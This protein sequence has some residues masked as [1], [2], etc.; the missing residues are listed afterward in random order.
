MKR[1]KTVQ[2]TMA[3]PDTVFGWSKGEV[4]KP[5]TIN[6]RTFKPERDGLFCEKIFGPTKDYEC[7][8]GKYKGKK[9]E[10]TVCERCNVRVEPKSSRRK[11]M[12]HIQLAA[13]V[14]HLW[15]LKS[16]PSILSNLLN[17]TSKNLENIIYFGSR[18]II[19][20]IFVIVDRKDTAFDNGDTLYET[21]HDIYSLFWDFEAE[22]AVTVK[23]PTGPVKSEIQG[24]VSI[25]EEETHTGKTLYWVTVTDKVS[26]PYAV[27]KNRTINFKGGQEIQAGQ[28]LVS[29]QTIPAI[30]SPIDGT[31]ELDEGLGTLTIDPIITSGDQPVNFQIPFNA[32]VTVK[33]ND[34]VKKGDRLTLEVTYPAILAEKS[35][36]VVFDKGLSVKPLPDGRHEA[37]SNGKVL[38]ENIIEQKRYPI[39]EGSILYVNEGEMVEKD[40]HI[41]DR[42]VYEEEILSLTEYRILEEHYPGMFNAEG[43][44]ENDRPIMV[45]TEIDP[46]VSTEIEKEAGDILT[47]NEYEAYRTVY[48]GKIEARTGAEAVKILLTKL[49]LE[50][51]RVE[52]ENELRELPKSSAR[53]IKLRKR[54][55]IIKDLLLSGNDPTWMVLNVLPVIPPELR[56][57]IQIEGGRFATTDLNDL[58]R[59]VI[60]RNNRLE[61]LMK[62]N[63]PEVIVRNEKRMLQQAVDALIYNGRMSKAITDR[64]G[65]PLKSLTDLLKGKKGRFRRNLLGKRV[66]YSGRAVIVVGPD[67]KIH[68]CGVPKKMALELF[69][70]FVLSKLLGDETTSKS[71]RKLKKAI[72]EKEMPQAWEVLEEVIREHPV[73]LNR[74]P[75][76]HRISIQAFMPR[77]VEG[78]AI[79]LHPLVCPPFN[80]DFDGDQMAVHVPLSA[81]AQAEAKWLMLSRYNII[82]PANGEPLSMPGKDIILGIYYLTMCEKDIDKID[83]KDIPFRF[84]NFV[85]VLIALEHSSHRKELSIVNTENGP[86]TVRTKQELTL[87]TPILYRYRLSNGKT[88]IVKT[89]PGRA[90]FNELLPE[91]YKQ[92]DKVFKKKEIKNLVYE[93]FKKF[94]IDRTADLLDDIKDLGF[95]YATVSGLTISVK[96]VLISAQ[97]K[98]IIEKSEKRIS[99]V[100]EYY[101][102]GF[103][104]PLERYREIIKIWDESTS[105]VLKAT[106]KNMADHPY[107]PLQ[108]MVSSGAR[109]NEDQL[110]Q[111]AGMRGLMAGPAGN[112][113]EIPIRANFREGLSVLEFFISTHG[114]RKGAADTALRTSNAGYLTRRLVDVAQSVVVSESDCGTHKGIEATAL[115]DE[116][117]EIEGLEKNIFGRVIAEPIYEPELGTPLPHPLVPGK[118]YERDTMLTGDDAKYLAK[119]EKR[120]PVKKEYEFN[121]SED[122]RKDRLPYSYIEL[123]EHV[124][125]PTGMLLFQA[126]TPVNFHLLQEC[127]NNGIQRIAVVEYP[128]VGNFSK[129]KALSKDGK[130]TIVVEDEKIDPATARLLVEEEVTELRVRPTI[131]IRNVFTCESEDGVCA[132]CYGMDLSNHQIVNIGEAVGTVAA[133]SIGEPGTQ[134]TMRTFHT[135]GIASTADITQGLPRA[136]ELFEAR[137]KLKENPAV[138]STVRGF[139]KDIKQEENGKTKVYVEDYE[140]SIHDYELPSTLKA[141]V[142]IGD[143]LLP[144]SSISTGAVR[145]RELMQELDVDT[146]F[147]YLLREIKRVYSEQG[148]DIHNKHIEIIIRQ[149]LGKVEVVEPGDTDYLVGDLVSFQQVKKTNEIILKSNAKVNEN[150]KRVLDKTVKKRILISREGEMI[151]L[152]AE[153]SVVTEEL[154]KE[155]VKE[156]IKVVEIAEEEQTKEYQIN[157]KE[158]VKYRRKLLRITKASLER[159][160]WLSAASFQQTAQVLTENALKGSIDELKGLKENVIIG[161]LVP[162]GT[163]M[164]WYSAIDYEEAFHYEQKTAPGA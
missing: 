55:Q 21:E 53:V 107:N 145:P 71:A 22:P 45:I 8:C 148:V 49:D 157:T 63:A 119:Y 149:M 64:G 31:V 103:L 32:R 58:Y 131:I 20:K 27:H 29:E 72:I 84:T 35:G 19:E 146:T 50:K 88:K 65:R 56:P 39:V 16:T 42:F 141:K 106:V 113:I 143:K 1:V 28:Q 117:V 59:R 111:L 85:E 26:E 93:I 132:K 43:E 140:E 57:M 52:I 14:V 112:I 78:N 136:E 68:E 79:R 33:D 150:R 76:L 160:G 151:E 41:A 81:K 73:L 4:K 92:Y 47:D 66:D 161:Q 77:L 51:I 139:V 34:K 67:L 115:R 108:M 116:E 82:S 100:E 96:D 138:F 17:M 60:N 54:L 3:S 154:L 95:H 99:E 97:R 11:N 98:K 123:K 7:S 18:R 69:K 133:Q 159:I 30:Y 114:G 80:A 40:A 129:Q 155:L 61:K 38:I 121:L 94:G 5:E 48:P 156:G 122:I 126:E 128:I 120:V 102:Y 89:T 144:G 162:A 12:G 158:P 104:T 101:R 6:Y 25:T 130:R 37:T 142:K 44:I 2:I 147:K 105:D 9:Y 36:T 110:K 118:V 13:P 74:A 124:M 153:G 134:L 163:G 86:T 125:A 15:F 127:K 46:E 70:P 109:G 23:N 91:E 90:I 152:A 24:M 75:T 10:G 164:D 135:G 137:K 62:L 83:A 87:H